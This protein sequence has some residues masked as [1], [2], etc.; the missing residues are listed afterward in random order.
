MLDVPGRR[1]ENQVSRSDDATEES[2]PRQ[3][4]DIARRLS[5]STKDLS[6]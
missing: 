3:R 6:A 4:R 5:L 1:A 2:Y